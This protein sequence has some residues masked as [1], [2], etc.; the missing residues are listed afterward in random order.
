M[1]KKSRATVE[2]TPATTA[3][4]LYSFEVFEHAKGG[5]GIKVDGK[6]ML[7][8]RKQPFWTPSRSYAERKL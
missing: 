1:Q 5:F 7:L 8:P 4:S 6:E 3:G 2:P